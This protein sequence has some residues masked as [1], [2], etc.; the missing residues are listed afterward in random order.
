M[1]SDNITRGSTPTGSTRSEYLTSKHPIGRAAQLGGAF[2]V[3]GVAVLFGMPLCPFA[4]VTHHPCPGCGLTRATLA[5]L[6]G[7]FAAAIRFHPLAPV[8]AP[9]L[10]GGLLIASYGYVRGGA[11]TANRRLEGRW[12]AG[13]G[14]VMCVAMFV[15]WVARFFGAFGGPVPV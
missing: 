5:M 12:I 2:A 9:V 13:I 6:H 15:V 10:I 7:D 14:I 1:A 4:L 3:V 11:N 8:V